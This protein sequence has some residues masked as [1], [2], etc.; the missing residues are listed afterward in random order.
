MHVDL[1]VVPQLGE[2]DLA[3][4]EGY[5]RDRLGEAEG[6]RGL[7]QATSTSSCCNYRR[8]CH[9]SSEGEEKAYCPYSRLTRAT[10]SPKLVR[11]DGLAASKEADVPE[12][13]MQVNLAAAD[14]W[15]LFG[16]A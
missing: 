14:P 15:H 3:E 6:L 10:H 1:L 4:H 16:D 11:D 7:L 13:K 8:K 12:Q 9:I 5:I 2:V